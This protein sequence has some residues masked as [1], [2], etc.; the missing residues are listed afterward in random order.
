[1][2]KINYYKRLNLAERISIEKGLGKNKSYDNERCSLS[3]NPG[4]EM[5]MRVVRLFLF[6]SVLQKNFGCK[7]LCPKG[8][9][10]LHRYRKLGLI[11]SP[12]KH[13]TVPVAAG[14][15]VPPAADHVEVKRAATIVRATT[16]GVFGTVRQEATIIATIA[17]IKS[18]R[19]VYILNAIYKWNICTS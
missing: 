19:T 13:N 7:I 2:K 15:A 16:P 11:K 17:S 18:C 6:F 9:D 12:S 8:Q 10:I 5:T 14:A 3:S 1:M 4:Q